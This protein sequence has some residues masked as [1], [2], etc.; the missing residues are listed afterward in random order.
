[1]TNYSIDVKSVFLFFAAAL[2]TSLNNPKTTVIQHRRLA[3]ADPTVPIAPPMRL[4]IPNPN[5]NPNLKLTLTLT[6]FRLF[7]TLTG[8][9]F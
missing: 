8:T 9:L 2:E 4:T 7:L 3:S 1:M 6:Y 5:P